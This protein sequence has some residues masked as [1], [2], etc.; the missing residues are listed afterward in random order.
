M[1][2]TRQYERDVEQLRSRSGKRQNTGN[3]EEV[4]DGVIHINQYKKLSK[5]K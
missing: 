3:R 4:G 1:Y 2:K 5:Q